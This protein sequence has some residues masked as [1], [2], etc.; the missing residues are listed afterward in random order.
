MINL[1]SKTLETKHLLLREHKVEDYKQVYNN[2]ANSEI[3]TKYLT[4]KAHENEEVTKDYLKSVEAK[5]GQKD[6]YYWAIVLK[7]TN[8]VIGG[9]SSVKNDDVCAELGYCLGVKYWNKGYATE[10]AKRLIDYAFCDL[11][12]QKIVADCISTNFS[13]S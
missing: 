13:P 8:E 10:C 12:A 4:W 2:Y 5:Y 11:G 1:G 9:I 3:V 6:V 7:E